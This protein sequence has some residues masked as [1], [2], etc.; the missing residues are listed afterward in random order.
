MLLFDTILEADTVKRTKKTPSL[1]PLIYLLFRPGYYLAQYGPGLGAKAFKVYDRERRPMG[2]LSQAQIRELM[3]LDV[4]KG[5]TKASSGT[6]A[7]FTISRQGIRALRGNHRLKRAY[8]QYFDEQNKKRLL[9][10]CHAP[11]IC[12]APAAI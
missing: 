4:L 10:P 2:Y 12:P 11:A 8:L 6:P 9:Q 5:I 1:N 7:R 3:L